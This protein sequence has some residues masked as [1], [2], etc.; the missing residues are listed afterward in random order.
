[1][2]HPWRRVRDTP[3]IDV[4]FTDEPV[5]SCFNFRHQRATI[6]RDGLQSERRT[7]VNHEYWHFR[8]GPLPEGAT[9]AQKDSEERTIEILSARELI[10]ISDLGEAMAWTSDMTEVADEL[11]VDL[12]CLW[13]RLESLTEHERKYLDRRVHKVTGSDDDPES[14]GGLGVDAWG[15]RGLRG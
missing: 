15:P 10:T 7:D 1:M 9:Q 8:R 14:N 2:F 6:A 11:W 5:Y 12:P 4:E 3:E 13:A